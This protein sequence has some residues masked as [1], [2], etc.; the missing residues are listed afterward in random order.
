MLIIARGL[1]NSLCPNGTTLLKSLRGYLYPKAS[2]VITGHRTQLNKVPTLNTSVTKC[3]HN[4]HRHKTVR[5]IKTSIT[6]GHRDQS[7]MAGLGH[8]THIAL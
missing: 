6:L 8:S 1:Y 5:M 3:D 4:R 7:S 2:K